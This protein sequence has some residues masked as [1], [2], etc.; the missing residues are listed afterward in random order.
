MASVWL[1]RGSRAARSAPWDDSHSKALQSQLNPYERRCETRGLR[2]DPQ[3]RRSVGG[4][5]NACKPHAAPRSPTACRC[6]KRHQQQP[7][8]AVRDVAAAVTHRCR[9]EAM[10]FNRG[11]AIAWLATCTAARE[12]AVSDRFT[13][14]VEHKPGDVSLGFRIPRNNSETLPN[15]EPE[16]DLWVDD[17]AAF[18]E[19]VGRNAELCCRLDGADLGCDEI[20]STRIT[21]P[22]KLSLGLHELACDLV[23]V[24][25]RRELL[26]YGTTLCRWT[27]VEH[28]NQTTEGRRLV[29]LADEQRMMDEPLYRWWRGQGP[30][31]WSLPQYPWALSKVEKPLLVVG[32]KC[33]A[34][35][36]SQRDAMRRTWLS[37]APADGSLI[38]R[39]VIG[40]ANDPYVARAL[41][42][43]LEVYNDVLIPPFLDLEDGYKSLVPKTK[44]FASY[45]YTQYP[46]ASYVMLC[47]DDV[48][49]DVERLLEAM[50]GSL[51][52]RRFYAGQVWA[53][54]FR[55]PTLPQRST[56]HRN[57]LPEA[58]YPMSQLPPFAIGP[59]YLLSMDCAAFI[60]KNRDDLAG[61][62]TLEDV[63][64]AL[65]LLALQVHPQHS[66]QFTN[67]RLFGCEAYS[68]SIADL[69]SR[70]IRAIH[71]NRKNGRDA[72]E[73]YEELAWVKT[74]RFKL[75]T[76]DALYAVPVGVDGVT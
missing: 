49:V 32:V 53:E 13:G 41:Q 37:D 2:S 50:H 76:P 70:G 18:M 36:I 30:L 58:V 16:I 26:T 63:S 39:F 31:P 38:V 47:D 12:W 73:G 22:P 1:H 34:A 75:Q 60:H 11:A 51:P 72:C 45:A 5:W 23:D 28:V 29:E 4:G 65:W 55:K 24:A 52:T 3:P 43:E 68:V 62:G 35:A 9:R 6:A 64:V 61:V 14:P 69:T 46:S 7:N 40:R 57:Y 48:L 44:A 21:L 56:T 66:E 74:P 42:R 54:H 17:H 67:A 20:G 33:A 27:V 59:H 8:Q 19:S 10:R 25:S 15:V 71:A